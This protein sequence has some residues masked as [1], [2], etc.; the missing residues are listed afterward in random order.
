[1]MEM[2]VP[3]DSIAYPFPDDSRPAP[4]TSIR[5][6]LDIEKAMKN[7]EYCC[8]LNDTER[9]LVYDKALDRFHD[10]KAYYKEQGKHDNLIQPFLVGDKTPE[11][12]EYI[13][14]EMK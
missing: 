1:M 14:Q 5:A 4:D 2:D 11:S 12:A 10:Y 8:T 13:R 3:D 9:Q 7:H 6:D